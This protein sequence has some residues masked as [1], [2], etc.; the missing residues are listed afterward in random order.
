MSWLYLEII[1]KGIECFSFYH[2]T[3]LVG[4]NMEEAITTILYHLHLICNTGELS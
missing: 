4:T 1:I 2:L 3:I